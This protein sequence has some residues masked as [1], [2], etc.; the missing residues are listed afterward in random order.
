M[1]LQSLQF[2]LGCVSIHSLQLCTA[3]AAEEGVVLAQVGGEELREIPLQDH[4]QEHL[5]CCV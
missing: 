1:M 3:V 5:G 2:G 4:L